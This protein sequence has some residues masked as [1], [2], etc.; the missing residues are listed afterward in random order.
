VILLILALGPFLVVGGSTTKVGLPWKLFQ[1]PVINNAAPDR[2]FMYIY[3]ELAICFALWLSGSSTSLSTKIGTVLITVICMLPNLSADFWTHPA[4][5]VGF[6]SSDIYK[7]YLFKDENVLILPFG[8]RGESMYWQAETRMYFR[9]AQGAVLP[10]GE[11]QLWPIID[12]FETQWYM[13]GSAAQLKAYLL[14]HKVG[15]VIVT[16]SVFRLWKDLLTSLEVA[17]T[18]VGGVRIY[19]LSAQFTQSS[20]PSLLSMR[21]R[22]D[23]VRFESVIRGVEKYISSGGNFRSLNAANASPLGI[24]PD[25]EIVGPNEPFAFFRVPHNRSRNVNYRYGVALFV[26]ADDQIA[27]GELAWY[28]AVKEMIARYQPIANHVEVDWPAG[29]NTAKPE[30]DTPGRFVMT[31]DRERLKRAA[32]LASS[33]LSKNFDDR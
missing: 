33:A 27:I 7:H 8:A 28:P 21:N 5:S 19:R 1:V 18:E 2:F 10:P 25:D 22:Y 12:A 24:I 30:P 6:F 11:F 9:M 20:A 3:L 26:T 14:A 31:F 29:S 16:D 32:H 17:P 13:P 4:D 15:V 23:V